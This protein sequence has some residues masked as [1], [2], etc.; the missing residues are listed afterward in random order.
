MASSARV[1]AHLHTLAPQYFR[2]PDVPTSKASASA[3]AAAESQI[4][5]AK[6]ASNGTAVKGGVSAGRDMLKYTLIPVMR[7]G[8]DAGGSV[9]PDC[10]AP[11]VRWPQIFSIGR[12]RANRRRAA[13][14]V[15]VR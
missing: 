1:H 12:Q 11:A 7:Q 3:P 13:S 4:S 5:N 9:L 8:L 10:S 14:L 2:I 15:D 6:G